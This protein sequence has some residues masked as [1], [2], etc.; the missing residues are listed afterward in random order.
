M[1][2]AL[3]TMPF[4]IT[5][6][7][8]PP[9]STSKYPGPASVIPFE[10]GKERIGDRLRG[11][12][13]RDAASGGEFRDI[14]GIPFLPLKFKSEMLPPAITVAAFGEYHQTHTHIAG[15]RNQLDRL[16][17]VLWCKGCCGS[18]NPRPR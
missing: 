9:A 2:L 1:R 11:C 13:V 7:I 6:S 12:R 16:R 14:P 4:E 17:I 18:G 5:K 8:E 3:V 10:L 15:V